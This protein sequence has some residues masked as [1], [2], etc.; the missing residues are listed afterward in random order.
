MQKI[1]FPL[2]K[3]KS[4]TNLTASARITILTLQTTVMYLNDDGTQQ[5][6]FLGEELYRLK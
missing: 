1:I 2:R 4:L 3:K 6:A 5:Y